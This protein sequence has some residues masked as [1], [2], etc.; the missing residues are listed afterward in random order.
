MHTYLTREGT[1]RNVLGVKAQVDRVDDGLAR[2]EG[3]GIGVGPLGLGRG[4][5]PAAVDSD[6][7][8]SRSGLAC[9]HCE[10]NDK[11]LV[12]I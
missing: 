1:S 9:F 8:V 11:R 7:Q 2:R 3:Y 12:T 6:L 5:H 10:S 4:R